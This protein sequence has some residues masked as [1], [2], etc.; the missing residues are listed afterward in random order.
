MGGGTTYGLGLWVPDGSSSVEMS[1]ISV[2]GVSCES[3]WAPNCHPLKLSNAIVAWVP[4]VGPQKV[5]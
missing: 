3:I 1:I 5:V 2:V 4:K